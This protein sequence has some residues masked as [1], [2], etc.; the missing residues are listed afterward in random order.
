VLIRSEHSRGNY[1]A[2]TLRRMAKRFLRLL[3]TRRELSIL[4]TTDRRIARLNA[5]WRR[6]RQPTDVLSFAAPES[7]G[8]LGD[9]IISLDT[10]SRQAAERG[11]PLSDELARLLA[12]GML[13]LVGFDHDRPAAARR[14]A[15]AESDILGKAGLVA[16]NLPLA[17]RGGKSRGSNGKSSTVHGRR[18]A[19]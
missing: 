4:V 6:I 16:E 7:S 13:H 15:R 10:A 17:S 1:A 18:E 2:R 8:T 11:A 5:S 14:M 19:R 3:G 9:V 12:H